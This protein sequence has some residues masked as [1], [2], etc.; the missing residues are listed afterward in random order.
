MTKWTF[1][2]S[3]TQVKI[4]KYKPTMAIWHKFHVYYD[5]MPDSKQIKKHFF[6]FCN[7]LITLFLLLHKTWKHFAGLSGSKWNVVKGRKRGKRERVIAWGAEPVRSGCFLRIWSG[8][9]SFLMAC[10]G[11]G[12]GFYPCQINK[13]V[14]IYFYT[15]L[16]DGEKNI[17]WKKW[18]IQLVLSGAGAVRNV[19]GSATPDLKTERTFFVR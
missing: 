14:S 18:I 10:S 4:F 12:S 19:V 3:Q 16:F 8:F 15:K 5:L 17:S 2:K 9:G 11:P 7:S 1:L 6:A 13:S